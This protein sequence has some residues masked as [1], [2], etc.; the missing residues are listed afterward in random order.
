MCDF[1]ILNL[2]NN[3]FFLSLRPTNL[4]EVPRFG[5]PPAPPSTSS[6]VVCPPGVNPRRDYVD[7]LIPGE[8]VEELSKIGK[9][10]FMLRVS[11]LSGGC[12]KV[13]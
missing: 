11:P 10:N 4:P 5:G 12:L 3:Y 9:S 8:K 2:K 7:Y 13:C 1:V 6:S